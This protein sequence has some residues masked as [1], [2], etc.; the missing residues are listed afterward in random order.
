[1]NVQQFGFTI[2]D[3]FSMAKRL[4]CS[5]SCGATSAVATKMAID[6]NAGRLPVEIV[7]YDTNSEHP[8][9]KRFLLDC[10]RWF[11][12]PV[13][14]VRSEKYVDI[15]DVFEKD[16]YI[17]GVNGARCTMVLKKR[18]ADA[19]ERPTDLQVLGF[20]SMEVKRAARFRANQPEVMGWFPLIDAGLSKEFCK[21]AVDGA[22]IELPIMYRLGFRN[23]NCIGCCKGGNEFWSMTR[24]HFPE[25]YLRMCE[26]SRRLN[27]RL[28]KLTINGVRVRAFLDELPL[29]AKDDE[30]VDMSCGIVC[31]QDGE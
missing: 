12:H 6:V 4:L 27:V 25:N 26:L 23:N 5:F 22:G 29:D 16:R 15:W 13:T 3:P 21:Q 14:V 2:S 8:D 11:G 28:L 7:Y 1:M 31:Q 19:F 30:P 20:D 9:N 18:P 17:S 24:K 10:Q